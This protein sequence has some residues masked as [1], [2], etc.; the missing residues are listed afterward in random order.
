M[1]LIASPP[2]GHRHLLQLWLLQACAEGMP[3]VQ[4]EGREPPPRH[5][6]RLQGEGAHQRALQAERERGVPQGGL[7]Q[8]TKV[9]ACVML[10]NLYVFPPLLISARPH[11]QYS[12][13]GFLRICSHLSPNKNFAFLGEATANG[14]PTP[15]PLGPAGK[16]CCPGCWVLKTSYWRQ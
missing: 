7:L 15:R 6:L 10:Y 16:T 9:T 11:V 12:S 13:T 4:A 1:A 3:E 2:G 8:G 14:V 5:V